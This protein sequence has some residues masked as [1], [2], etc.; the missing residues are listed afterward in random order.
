MSQTGVIENFIFNE[1]PL[2]RI[3]DSASTVEG[4]EN[5]QGEF[6][7][8]TEVYPG[9]PISCYEFKQMASYIDPMLRQLWQHMKNNA[10]TR[11]PLRETTGKRMGRGRGEPP[12]A[13]ARRQPRSRK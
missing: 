4:G 12:S 3:T 10:P 1:D 2:N 11:A 5:A 8:E 6:E 13:P 9:E 7:R